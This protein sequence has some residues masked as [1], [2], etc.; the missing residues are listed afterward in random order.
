MCLHETEHCPGKEGMVW[1]QGLLGTIILHQ[2]RVWFA[3]L[4]RFGKEKQEMLLSWSVNLHLEKE[5]ER[6]KIA[7][8][9][10]TEK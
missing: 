9:G 2:A 6:I 10:L 4:S 5:G 7:H 1:G 8:K 3:G